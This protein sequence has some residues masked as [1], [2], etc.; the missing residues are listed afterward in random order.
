MCVEMNHGDWSI[1][2]MERSKDREDDGV[3]TAKTRL[4][5]DMVQGMQLLLLPDDP[6][7]LTPIFRQK[8]SLWPDRGCRCERTRKQGGVRDFHLIY[9]KRI[10][11]RY[12]RDLDVR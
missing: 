12:G 11:K 7:M 4:R 8:C 9:C 10:V 2:F 5:K 3:I 1:D 6:W